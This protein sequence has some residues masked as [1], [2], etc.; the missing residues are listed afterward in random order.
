[1]PVIDLRPATD[2]VIGLLP[3]V[4]DDDLVR[5][6]PCEKMD[7]A[8]MLDHLVGLATAFRDAALKDIPPGGSQPPNA[9]GDRLIANW[10]EVLPERLDEFA[11]AWSKPEAWEGMTEAGS[12][13]AP[14]EI[15]GAVA[16]DEVVMHGWDLARATGQ[17]F[18]PDEQTAE[19][20]FAFTTESVKPE[21]AEQRANIFGPIVPVSED[22][23]IFDRALGLAGRSPDW[24]P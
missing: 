9:S 11:V 10:R 23:P 6:T 7:V 16:L 17:S 12:V 14:A 22:A 8:T 24:K 18:A 1:M 20:V 15:M 2:L 4:A 19:A 21:M 3:N 5:P 13:T